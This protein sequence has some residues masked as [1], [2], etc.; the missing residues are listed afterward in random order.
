MFNF[1]FQIPQV[2]H[3][4]SS[5]CSNSMG[6]SQQIICL[7]CVISK[8]TQVSCTESFSSLLFISSW[9]GGSNEEVLHT[10]INSHATDS[11]T[12][13]TARNRTIRSL[14]P[15]MWVSK[16]KKPWNHFMKRT[17]KVIFSRASPVQKPLLGSVLQRNRSPKV[18]EC[19]D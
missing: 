10:A 13:F 19:A 14:N 9:W 4:L 11:G 16:F 1:K 15:I 12:S 3:F 5:C 7:Y 18:L 2:H 8:N 17:L 6:N